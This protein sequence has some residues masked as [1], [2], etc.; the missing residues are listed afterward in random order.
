MNKLADFPST[1]EAINRAATAERDAMITRGA[2]LSLAELTEIAGSSHALD[3]GNLTCILTIIGERMPTGDGW[4]SRGTAQDAA[5][6]LV[7]IK[8]YQNGGGRS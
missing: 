8:R 5:N 4:C 3:M 1:D 7:V 6:D 2:L